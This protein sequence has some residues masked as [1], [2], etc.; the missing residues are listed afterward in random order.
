M[1]T[2]NNK[3]FLQ[4][5][6]ILAFVLGSAVFGGAGY[7]ISKHSQNK[8]IEQSKIATS[9]ASVKGAK[10]EFSAIDETTKNTN[11]TKN[12]SAINTQQRQATDSNLKIAK[13]QGVY[14][15]KI[16]KMQ[17]EIDIQ[18]VQL[19]KQSGDDMGVNF[20]TLTNEIKILKSK[21][22][23]LIAQQLMLPA[24]ASGAEFGAALDTIDNALS[25]KNRLLSAV[26]SALEGTEK[27]MLE[28]MKQQYKEEY[29]NCLD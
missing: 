20:F 10:V 4:L 24:P 19:V 27:V 7:F 2:K 29:L 1:N 11:D 13:C 22:D 14:D 17:N 16:G 8:N 18:L 3:G 9:T 15:V 5:P 28:Q 23:T 12:G 6:I 26:N 25:E 21:K